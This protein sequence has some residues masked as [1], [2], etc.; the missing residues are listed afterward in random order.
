MTLNAYERVLKEHPDPNHRFRIEHAQVVTLE[1]IPRFA[2]L[3][4]IPA[5]QTVHATSDMNMA[6]KR[7]G[8]ERIKGAYAWRKFLSS[9]SIIANGTDAPVELVNPFTASMQR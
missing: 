3:G 5:L 9:G 1:D 7:I 8:P 4:V 2:R 6:E